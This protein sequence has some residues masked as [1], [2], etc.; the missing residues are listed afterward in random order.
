MNPTTQIAKKN[1]LAKMITLRQIIVILS[2]SEW[3]G[4][5]PE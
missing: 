1:V 3:S 5:M 4:T 2:T